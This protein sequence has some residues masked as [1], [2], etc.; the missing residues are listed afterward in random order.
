MDEWLRYVVS[1]YILEESSSDTLSVTRFVSSSSS[2]PIKTASLKGT[3]YVKVALLQL[4]M[5]GTL[6]MAR[7]FSNERLKGD[8]ETGLHATDVLD[9]NSLHFIQ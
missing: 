3:L 6:S 2:P 4:R 1:M 9:S 8:V 7:R 5:F